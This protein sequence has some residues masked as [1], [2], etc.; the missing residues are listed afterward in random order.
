MFPA[1]T[2]NGGANVTMGPLDT[3]K[4]PDPGGPVPIPYANLVDG[5]ASSGDEAA[6]RT[7]KVMIDAAAK[8]GYKAESATAAAIAGFGDSA[9]ISGGL[10]STVF[11]DKTS[12]KYGVSKV[13]FEGKSAVLSSTPT[14]FNASNESP[15]HIAPSQSKVLI[16]P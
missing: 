13:K 7:K 3:C 10:K 12:F 4:T 15:T 5:L 1:T 8:Q 14:S 9:G 2:K 11:M 6:I 16:M